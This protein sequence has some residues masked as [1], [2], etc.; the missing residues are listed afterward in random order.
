MQKN[1]IGENAGKIYRAL[2]SK[3]AM[4]I[5]SVQKE[6]KISDS[7]IFN[8]AVGWLARENKID[9]R[10]DAKGWSLSLAGDSAEQKG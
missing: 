7:G 5:T 3:G 1:D 9:F 8:Q 2:E 10:K 4:E 6:A